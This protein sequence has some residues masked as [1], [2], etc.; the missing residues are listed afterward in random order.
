MVLETNP[1]RVSVIV[2]VYNCERWIGACLD[3]ILA[4]DYPRDRY[5][6]IC[7]DNAS[8][9]GTSMVIEKYAGAVTVVHEAKRGAS[10]ARNAG[11]RVAA[12]P[13]IA[14]TDADC[15]V[16][17]GWLRR[18]VEPVS[19][20]EAAVA[21]GRIRALP[22]ANPVELFGELIHDH[23][24]AIR[25]SQPPY[26]IT[27]NMAAPLAL[28]QSVGCF[29]ERWLRMQDVDLSL[30]ILA[31][32]GRFAYVDDAVVYHRNRD[33]L[34]GL[35]REGL[36][37]GCLRPRFFNTHGE[38][39]RSCRRE[40]N[41]RVASETRPTSSP[42]DGLSAWRKLLYWGVFKA[43]RRFGEIRGRLF[44]RTPYDAPAAVRR[45]SVRWN[46]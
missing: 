15:V 45:K 12:G 19:A 42:A 6:V 2:S 28:L 4:S 10:A 24:R 17:P 8:T 43:G 30:R 3:S 16:D 41:S 46:S 40:N 38:F 44:N 20:G 29:D 33:T 1:P 32:G 18:I 37:H 26:V 34:W 9:D 39:I 21:G 7:A 27:M 11:L 36:L 14:F 35:A 22:N 25:L 13:M 31:A 23:A 5:E